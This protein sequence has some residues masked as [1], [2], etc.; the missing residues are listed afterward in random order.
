MPVIGNEYQSGKIILCLLDYA[1]RQ[2]VGKT[3]GFN[4]N[5]IDERTKLK[6]GGNCCLSERLG[7]ADFCVRCR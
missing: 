5:R 7:R 3:I 4:D 1:D 6:Q 2:L